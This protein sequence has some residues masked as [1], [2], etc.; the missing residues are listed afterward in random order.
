MN[1]T[2]VSIFISVYQSLDFI[3]GDA[4]IVRWTSYFSL[5]RRVAPQRHPGERLIG[6]GRVMGVDRSR[7]G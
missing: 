4:D 1:R 3:S 5:G 2:N 7:A 6:G